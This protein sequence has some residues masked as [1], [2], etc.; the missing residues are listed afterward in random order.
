MVV[1]L[2]VAFQTWEARGESLDSVEK[3]I[4]DG[5]PL[6]HLHRR[7]NEYLDTLEILFPESK[8]SPG[9]HILEIGSGVGY[10]MEA[11]VRRYA[12]QR[13]VGLD[14]ASGMIEKA[15]ERLAR[16]GVNTD[17]MEFVHYDSVDVPLPSNSFDYIYSVASLQHAPRPFCFRVLSEALRLIKPSGAVCIHLIAYSHF[18]N[19]MTPDQFAWEI[20]QQ[21]RGRPGH[22]HHYYSV[23]EIDMVLRY[24]LGVEHPH[25][26]EQAGS[27][28]LSFGKPRRQ[29]PIGL[30]PDAQNQTETP[31]T[32]RKALS[33]LKRG[34]NLAVETRNWTM[35]AR[36]L[37][38]LWA[39]GRSLQQ[40]WGPSPLSKAQEAAWN[41][42]G[43]VVLPGLFDR[44]QV[45]RM[46]ALVD[47]LWATRTSDD[48]DLIID[49]FIGTPNERRIR[50]RNA[51]DEARMSPYKLDDVYL[52]SDV[53]REMVLDKS[54]VRVLDRLLV[55]TP[56]AFN[57]LTFERGSQQEFHFDTFYMPPS[58]PNKMCASW[59][60]LEDIDESAGPLVF[61]PGSHKIPP[62]YFSD[63]RL[64][65]TVEE[66]GSFREY[67]ERELENRGLR[68]VTFPARAGD[69]FIW[70]AQLFHG[71]APILDMTRTRRSIVTHYFRMRE[72]APESVVHIGGGRFYLQ[73]PHQKAYE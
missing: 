9:G 63:G 14:V 34:R 71:G 4:H 40:S 6:A 35:V 42:D 2:D 65:V 55:G 15:R 20:D 61:Y 17:I 18:E 24:G 59:I 3:R 56:V 54:L 70:H 48:R 21:V 51:T 49:V 52:V 22:W 73:R 5:V 58:V 16:D 23:Q 57:S 31:Y 33:L 69:V 66:L 29:V 60:A 50:F 53:A 11:A 62:Y 72:M 44:E 13:I 64:N 36:R 46:N 12:P 43:Y 27:L 1:P 45:D 7:A 68:P 28:F 8:P 19:H 10:V 39:R 30:G 47:E 25:V 37:Q 26:V 32:L 67:V 41:N 38:Q